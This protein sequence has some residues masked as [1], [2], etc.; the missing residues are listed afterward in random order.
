MSTYLTRSLWRLIELAY[1][2]C[3]W[4]VGSVENI[5][6]IYIFFILIDYLTFINKILELN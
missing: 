3:V 2:I 6:T 1:V 4:H 5:L